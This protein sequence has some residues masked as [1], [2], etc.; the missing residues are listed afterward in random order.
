MTDQAQTCQSTSDFVTPKASGYLQQ[1]CKHFG[2][3]I[4]AVFDETSGSLTFACGE[5]RLTA[6][7]GV[8]RMNLTSP[9]V[10]QLEQLQDIIARHLVRFAFREEPVLEWRSS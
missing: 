1:L 6:R 8:L 10:P 3:K 5:C 2:H 9:D 7:D 4:P